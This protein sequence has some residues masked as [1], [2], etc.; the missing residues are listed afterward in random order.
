MFRIATSIFVMAPSLA[1]AQVDSAN[2]PVD[3]LPAPRE[4]RLQ[5]RVVA[6]S[7]HRNGVRTIG[8]EE[9]AGAANLARLLSRESGVQIRQAGGLGS[10]TTASLHASPVQ[11]VEVWMDGVPM[12]GST[13]SVVDLG[14]VPLDGLEKVEIRQAG[15]AGAFGAPR[16]DLQSR[17]GWAQRGA[18][19]RMASYG[20]KGASGWWGDEQGIATVSAWWEA[21]QNDYPFPWDNGTRYNRSDDHVVR[22]SN[23]DYEGRGAAFR[24][25]PAASWDVL[26][27]LDDSRR[28]ISAPGW[29]DPLARLDGTS[30]LGFARWV[31]ESE[32]K[33]S[34][35]ASARWFKSSWNDPNRTAG[36][37]VDRAASE[38]A[39]DAKAKASL[40]RERGGWL[41]GEVTGNVRLETS[42]RE[43]TGSADVA[44]TP[45]GTRATWG[46]QMVWNGQ[47]E[48]A[49]WGSQLGASKDWILDTRDWTESLGDVSQIDEME[50][51][52]ESSRVHGRLWG[53]PWP[54]LEGWVASSYRERAPDFREWMGDNGYTLQ[55][56]DLLAER[57]MSLEL[58]AKTQ[59]GDWSAN[60]SGWAQRYMDPIETFHKG[61]SPL[62]AH[63]NAAGY[64]AFGLDGRAG[65][66][67]SWIR[68]TAQGSLQ[69][70]RVSDDNPALD[71]KRPQR[72][73]LWKSGM[74]A[75]IGPWRGWRLGGD[76]S[77]AGSTYASALNR[78]TDLREGKLDLGAWLRWKRGVIG[79]SAQVD[80]ILDEHAQ[81]WEDLPQPGRR[82]SIRLDFE[83]S[84]PTNTRNE[85]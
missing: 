54:G 30:A 4:A 15:S 6:S 71:G 19:L 63:R 66:S 85:R 33:P 48:S 55:T 72:F 11:Q 20:E 32:T 14:P 76:L 22:L 65:W 51:S 35:E 21:S 84:K 18:S 12:G 57:S 29:V 2:P 82:F 41:D 70:A 60:I 8:R 59:R 43:S 81:D 78:P 42:E 62:V 73:P 36:W 77:L 28:G 27:R 16:I 52:W 45:S 39:W 7:V 34:V 64:D 1:L 79:A 13:G 31:G 69:S 46:G 17:S 23:N 80:N 25:R 26:A 56:P 75:S 49:R 61:A 68:A 9:L 58:G 44:V 38:Q 3:S 10:Y 74:D 40:A 50:T 53:R 24:W 83:F 37:D 47:S 67:T 5:E